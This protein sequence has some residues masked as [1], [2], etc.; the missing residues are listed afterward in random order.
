MLVLRQ[1]LRMS[2]KKRASTKIAA[3]V[4]A[5]DSLEPKTND[6]EDKI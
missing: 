5:D 3:V 1:E 6:S 4:Y 2:S